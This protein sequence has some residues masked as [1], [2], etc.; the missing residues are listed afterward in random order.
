MGDMKLIRESVTKKQVSGAL[1]SWQ[2]LKWLTEISVAIVNKSQDSKGGLALQSTGP[3][4]SSIIAA[5]VNLGGVQR[6]LRPQ[7]SVPDGG[8]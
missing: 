7:G 2:R 5:H 4:C 6:S 3:Q 8:P 1:T